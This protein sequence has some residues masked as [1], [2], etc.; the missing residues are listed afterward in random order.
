MFQHNYL[1]RYIT[2]DT[3]AIYRG[4]APQMAV[5]RAA[6]GMTRSIDQ[7]R[8]RS[9][10]D[11]QLAQVSRHPE[12]KLLRRSQQSLKKRIRARYG[13]ISHT[14]G[15]EIH[16]LYQGACRRLQSKKKAVKKAM[17]AEIRAK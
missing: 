7:R 14:E 1:S 15:T 12:V 17:M 13:A 8:S 5:M 4:L 6:S 11:S 3:Q 16:R 9:L 2:Q 10:D